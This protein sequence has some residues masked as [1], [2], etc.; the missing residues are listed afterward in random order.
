[1]VNLSQ[2]CKEFPDEQF[3]APDIAQVPWYADIV[4][5]LVIGLFLPGA[6]TNQKQ[7]MKY[8]ARFYIGDESYLFKQGPDQIMRRFIVEKEEKQVLESFHSSPYG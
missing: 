4:N 6:S 5:F 1:M 2:I 8:D 3:L 7:R